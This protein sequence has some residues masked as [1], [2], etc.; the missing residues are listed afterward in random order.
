MWPLFV[1]MS[2]GKEGGEGRTSGVLV[3]LVARISSLEEERKKMKQT[4]N[5]RHRTHL[6]TWLFCMLGMHWTIRTL[7]CSQLQGDNKMRG[8]VTVSTTSC[9]ICTAFLL[10][11][12]KP[13][14]I[15]VRGELAQTLVRFGKTVGHTIGLTKKA[16]IDETAAAE[17]E[18]VGFLKILMQY[19][20]D[21]QSCHRF[22]QTCWQQ[23]PACH[24]IPSLFPCFIL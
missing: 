2:N 5:Q 22:W 15:K 1:G 21:L 16:N 24:V 10:W 7:P 18:T 9:T 6:A 8:Y 11:K 23:F 14:V 3:A 17:A 12:F 4:V 13:Q 19:T 20:S